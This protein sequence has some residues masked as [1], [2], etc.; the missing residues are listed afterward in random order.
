[1]TYEKVSSSEWDPAFRVPFLAVQEV[2]DI[3]EDGFFHASIK[4]DR[5][6][7]AFGTRGDEAPFVS[8]VGHMRSEE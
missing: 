5:P 2:E 4:D 1:M 7:G 8:R 3:L 6:E